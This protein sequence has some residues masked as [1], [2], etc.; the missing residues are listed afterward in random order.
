MWGIR[1][2]DNV[3]KGTSQHSNWHTVRAQEWQLCKR[4]VGHLRL[5]TTRREGMETSYMKYMFSISGPPKSYD[6]T[7]G[8]FGCNLIFLSMI[9]LSNHRL[10]YCS[11]IHSRRNLLQMLAKKGFWRGIRTVK[12]LVEGKSCSDEGHMLHKVWNPVRMTW[13]GDRWSQRVLGGN[14]MKSFEYHGKFVR[15]RI[16]LKQNF[17][18]IGAL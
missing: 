14:F 9:M 15:K 2:K 8:K 17:I 7:F 4:G 11:H 1:H 10:C 13:N 12:G 16:S 6:P 18:C 5:C 3:Q